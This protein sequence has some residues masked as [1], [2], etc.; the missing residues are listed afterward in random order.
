VERGAVDTDKGPAL[1]ETC[2][3]Q[4]AGSPPARDKFSP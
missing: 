1:E 3:K 2:E 4:R